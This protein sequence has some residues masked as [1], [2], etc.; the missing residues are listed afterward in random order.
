MKPQV[1]LALEGDDETFFHDADLHSWEWEEASV[2]AAVNC[3]SKCLLNF[4]KCK[5]LL[6]FNI[7]NHAI[8]GK[9]LYI[10]IGKKI[11]KLRKRE[12]MTIW[13]ND[14][15]TAI[16]LHRNKYLPFLLKYT[17]QKDRS[18]CWFIH[19]VENN[20]FWAI[21]FLRLH[22]PMN[23]TC[24]DYC[25]NKEMLIH[26]YQNGAVFR[27]R[28]VKI[29][30]KFFYNIIPK[31]SLKHLEIENVDIFEQWQYETSELTIQKLF[32]QLVNYFENISKKLDIFSFPFPVKI[33]I[34]KHLL[35]FPIKHD[36]VFSARRFVYKS[37]MR[38]Q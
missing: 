8:V 27:R 22:Y 29:H 14:V 1:K 38:G 36:I 21:S 32:Y 13:G 16:I 5:R 37:N 10:L 30:P 31:L 9:T 11:Q 20:N 23:N 19:A 2:Y 15:C 6:D 18:D 3:K 28:H 12:Y 34:L 24:I 26:L 7:C 35:V 17:C 33:T 25:K 4:V